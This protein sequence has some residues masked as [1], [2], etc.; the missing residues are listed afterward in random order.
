MTG[1]VCRL[2]VEAGGRGRK[3]TR[4]RR[5]VRDKEVGR[6]M[7]HYLT[8]KSSDVIMSKDPPQLPW[9][10]VLWPPTPT[11]RDRHSFPRT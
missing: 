5:Q 7:S 8:R 9:L 4:N 2:G 10:T 6:N 3:K 11:F 1:K